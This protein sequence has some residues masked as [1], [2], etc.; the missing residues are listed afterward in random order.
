MNYK[1]TIYN[2]K[3][4]KEIALTEQFT[5]MTIGTDKTCQ[6]GLVRSQYF[7]DFVIDIVQ[8][9]GGFVASCDD[10]VYFETGQAS[11]LKV[12]N[13]EPGM[14]VAICYTQSGTIV[15]NMDLSIDFGNVQDNYNLAADISGKPQILIGGMAG[16]DVVIHDE[17]IGNG[18][19]TLARKGNGFQIRT[20]NISFGVTVNGFLHRENSMQ[21]GDNQFFSVCGNM[22][23]LSGNILYM[24]DSGR[25]TTGLPSQVI[26]EARNHYHYPQFVRNVRQQYKVPDK[27]LEVLQPKSI[28]E[29]PKKNLLLVL[30][31]IVLMM[32]L[33]VFVRGKMMGRSGNNGYIIYIAASMAISGLM[34]VI[35]YFD[36]GRDY[37]KKIAR[38]VVKY[39]EYLDKKEDEIQKL[40]LDEKTVFSKR[41]SSTEETVGFINDFDARLFEKSKG[42]EDYLDVR[43]GTGTVESVCQ[44]DF[45]KQEYLETED[46]LVEYPEKMHDK[47]QYIP[48]MPVVLH[49]ASESAVGFIGNRNKLYQMAKNLIINIAGQ[50]MFREVKMYMIMDPE[51]VQYFAWARWFQNFSDEETGMRNFMYDDESGKVILERLYNELSQ[52][53][54]AD[55]KLREYFTDIIVFVYRP[56]L[57]RNHPVSQYIDAAKDLGFTFLFFEENEEMLNPACGQRV[58]LEA[59][60]DR[61]FVQDAADG[62]KVQNFEYTHVDAATA[63]GCALKLGCVYISEVNLESTLTK[64]ISL[65]ELLGIMSAYDLDLGKRWENSRIYESMAAPLGVNSAGE[66]VCLDIHERFHGPHGLVAGT[67]GSG[68]SEILQS[69]VL[70][71]ATLFHPYEVGF[72]IIDFKGGGMANQFRNLP[73]LNGAITNIDGKQIDRSLMSIRA[74]L[75]KRQ[76]LFAK[77]GVNK[78]DDYIRLFKNGTTD[79]PLPHLILIVDEFAELKSDQPEFM[80]ELISAARIGRSLGVHLILA[81]QKPAGVVNDQIWS[82]SKFKLCL[83]VQDKSDS[84]EVLKSPLA[85][86]I[87]EPGRA[88]LQVGNNEIF[89]LF[90]SAY[91]GAPAKVGSVDSVNSFEIDSVNLAGKRA[92]VYKQ[93]P[94][95]TAESETQLDQLV[96][97][98]NEYCEKNDIHK[99]PDI[100]L[101]PLPEVLP[102][103]E[104]KAEKKDTTDIIIPIGIYDDPSRQL[105][106]EL[107]INLTQNHVFIM[108]SSLSGKTYLLQNMIMG[109]ALRYSPSDVNMYMLDFASMILRTFDDLNHVGSVI[110]ISEEDKLKHFM[111][112]MQKKLDDRREQLSQIGLSSYSAYR[113]AGYREMPQIVVFLENYTVFR[114]TFPEYED[115]FLNMCRDGVSAGISF[116]ITNQQLAGIGYKLLTNFAVKIALHC[117]DKGQYSGL[118]DKC[119]L[120]PD[121]VAGRGV[122]VID[123]DCKE[124]QSYLAFSSGM[125]VE[126]IA[127]IRK[128]IQEQN[129]RYSGE[130]ADIIVSVPDKITDAYIQK[131]FGSSE[132]SDYRLLAGLSY[133]TTLAEYVSLLDKPLMGIMGR[134]DLGRTSYVRYLL[135]KLADAETDNPSRLYVIDG[136]AGSLSECSA[137][138]NTAQ[139]SA[140]ASDAVQIIAT[141]YEEAQKRAELMAED[142]GALSKYPLLTAV[143]NTAVVIELIKGNEETFAQYQKLITTYKRCRICLIFTEIDNVG[144]TIVSNPIMKNLR[145]CGNLLIFENLGDIKIIN[146]PMAAIRSVKKQSVSGDACYISGNSMM[147]IKAPLL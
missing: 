130:H 80:K 9:N 104:Y 113:Q 8:R 115:Q 2:N 75:M 27:K 76:E 119:H 105:Q 108:G 35:N 94:A 88:Y 83:K 55:K 85:A 71:M 112:T 93:K 69:Y 143:F 36:G 34:A 134:D 82:N 40:R 87:R 77:Y 49:L 90:Q 121:N 67:T 53:E 103:P 12:C 7:A 10:N 106:K 43:I 70:S 72:I 24:S 92:V 61:G 18:S 140:N 135:K 29:K 141:L 48:D 44:I 42:Q 109:L 145:D 33:M 50:Y 131:R 46:E 139:Y 147:R 5:H 86:E 120:Y 107:Q 3:I 122:T 51:D 26:R 124:F 65:Y 110:T 28:P 125:E 11:G 133:K 127:G 25:I 79:I 98:I 57:I 16:A 20:E 6:I 52:R 117:N 1:L 45:H 137:Y 102:Y 4:Y 13:L 128:F 99:L 21:L 74:E 15:F 41:N 118:L 60:Q 96:G 91:S 126:R 14:D 81:T 89:E 114:A 17:W 129:A 56:E 101:P 132:M 54:Q 23:Y 100:C 58:F 32:F 39:N 47:Y 62:V 138:G 68:K 37:K 146:V 144:V 38:R 95:K 123:N 63:A 136:A 59:D 66:T 97:F 111:E 84:N 116:V 64:N 142:A 30:M 73:H 78:I 19:I 31:P 22:F